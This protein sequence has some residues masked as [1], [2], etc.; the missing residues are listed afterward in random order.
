MLQSKDTDWL[1]GYKKKR[2]LYM[3]STR[4][5]LQISEHLQTES[6]SME[7]NIQ[8]KWKAKESWSN[9]THIRQNRL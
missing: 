5:P 1:N 4:G 9:N 8:C 6:E 7:K 3:L 2:P